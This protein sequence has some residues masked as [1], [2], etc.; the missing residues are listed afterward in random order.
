[1]V[2]DRDLNLRDRLIGGFGSLTRDVARAIG[3][4]RMWMIEDASVDSVHPFVR[5]RIEPG[6]AIHTDGC[7][8][9]A[10]PERKGWSPPQG[11]GQV[12]LASRS[13][14]QTMIVSPGRI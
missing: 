1:M 2:I 14:F 9:Y 5:D 7:Q 12:D 4:I 8:G 13:S 10:G 3:R 6:S 11:R